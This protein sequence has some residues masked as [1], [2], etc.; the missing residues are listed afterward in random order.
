MNLNYEV[1]REENEKRSLTLIERMGKMLFIDAYAERTHFIFELLQNAEDAIARRG[2]DWKGPRSVSFDLTQERLRVSHFGDPFNEADVRGICG[3]GDSTKDLTD[4][5]RFGI[6][7]KSV[8]AFTDCP[9]IHSGSES[10]A[11]RGYVRPEAVAP[12]DRQPDETVFLIPFKLGDD[13][14]H[15]EIA[16]GLRQLD[17][18]TLLFLRQIDEIKWRIQD[19]M[20]GQ[21]VCE[22]RSID[23]EVRRITIIGQPGELDDEHEEWLVFSREVFNEYEPAGYVEIAFSL[24]HAGQDSMAVQAL[25]RSSLAVFFPTDH[26]THLSFLAHGPYQTTPSRD[27][28]PQ[29]EYWNQ[30]LV[31]ETTLLLTDALR[32]FRDE[33]MLNAEVLKCLPI[34]SSQFDGTMFEALFTATKKALCDEPL[35]PK[36]GGGHMPAGAALLGRTDAIRQLL[37]REQ[38]SDLWP[39]N[40]DPDWLT[41]DITYDRTRDIRDYLMRELDVEEVDSETFV[42]KLTKSFLEQQTDEWIV[43]LYEFLKGQPALLKRLTDI[44]VVRLCDGSHVKAKIGNQAQAFLPSDV[45]TDFPIVRPSVC[46]SEDALA[47]LHALGLRKPDFVDDVIRNVISKYRDSQSSVDPRRYEADIRRMVAA[48]TRTDSSRQKGRLV[49]SLRATAFVMAVDS[50]DDDDTKRLSLPSDLYLPVS[51]PDGLF[52]G[53]KGTLFPDQSYDC[54]RSEEMR[55]LLT[56]CGVR[57]PRIIDVVMRHVLP[58]YSQ[59]RSEVDLSMY[60]DDVSRILAAY[61]ESQRGRQDQRN[62]LMN[63]LKHTSFVISVNAGTGSRTLRSPSQVYM[64]TENLNELLAGNS[65]F[66]IID[67]SRDCLQDHRMHALLEECGSMRHINAVEHSYRPQYYY[68]GDASYLSTD[69]LQKLR[70]QVGHSETSWQNDFV[71]DWTLPFLTGL[72][73][74]LSSL[75]IERREFVTRILW[76]ALI[77]LRKASGDQVFTGRYSWTHYGS[78]AASFDASFIRYLNSNRWVPDKDGNLKLPSAVLFSDLGW[79]EDRFLQSMVKFRLPIVDQLALASGID[80]DILDELKERNITDLSSFLEAIGDSPS[81]GNGGGGSANGESDNEEERSIPF[82]ELFFQAQSPTPSLASD[83]PLLLGGEGP[84]TEDSAVRHQEES[85]RLSPPGRRVHRTTNAWVPSEASRKLTAEFKS[86]VHGDYGRRCQVC[87]RAFAKPSGERQVFVVHVVPP[88]KDER[89]NYYGDLL[90]LCGWHYALVR[91]GE[92]ALLDPSNNRPFDDSKDS[93]GWT[94]MRSYILRA[95]DHREH[96]DEAGNRYVSLPVQFSNV[97]SKWKSKPSKE[98]AEIR[99]CIPHWTYLCQLIE[100]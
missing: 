4:I 32:W 5:G 95:R 25:D 38:L 69:E 84:L 51:D 3:I 10:F 99:Y 47:F 39:A 49:D 26:E 42:A 96:E 41:S 29:R 87:S 57:E 71:T 62:R 64:P 75:E 77:D 92:W 28:I 93:P 53:V 24:G 1:I 34:R 82:A 68:R 100:S 21:Y 90:G 85:R 22:S 61:V 65:S 88:S 7:F 50:G 35:L 48:Y 76:E 98:I 44:P 52:A 78:Y 13:A 14:G 56:E 9:E 27:T 33:N 70:Q 40:C 73:S 30:H 16:E 91:Y 72:V 20:S 94:D 2:S 45:E 63:H 81:P 86:M 43:E 19:S 15:A 80:P 54:L 74:R 66:Y 55:L 46:A 6:G 83:D 31:D 97:F 23:N 11:I 79:E 67:A 17:L 89:T 58:K 18:T 59:V 8:Y 36:L 60:D 37:S 12:V